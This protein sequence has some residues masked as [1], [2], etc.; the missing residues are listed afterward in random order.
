M[1]FFCQA[2]LS[3]SPKAVPGY[4]FLL[5][6]RG[7]RGRW[8]LLTLQDGEAHFLAVVPF[9]VIKLGQGVSHGLLIMATVTAVVYS[10]IDSTSHGGSIGSALTC[11]VQMGIC[12]GCG[13]D[14]VEACHRVDP[15]QIVEAL[16]RCHS[17]VVV[18]GQHTVKPLIGI[19]AE[20]LVGRVGAKG[21]NTFL[22]QFFDG[23]DDDDLLLRLLFFF[24]AL[25]VQCQDGYPGI[26]DE[27]VFLQVLVED[28][29]FLYNDGS[30][31]DAETLSFNFDTRV[32]ST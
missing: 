18:H 13:T 8:V 25:G 3:S 23:W 9:L 4:C 6:S 32:L 24:T 2:E 31:N 17:L 22:F 28:G 29:G 15:G 27:T 12:V 11:Y 14:N 10:L 16:E 26:G 5:F 21:L 20:E 30:V 19:C 1:L 7:G